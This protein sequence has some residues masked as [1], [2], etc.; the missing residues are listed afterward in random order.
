MQEKLMGKIEHRIFLND[1]LTL[2]LE[3]SGLYDTLSPYRWVANSFF[4]I[5][6]KL[7]NGE[8][9]RIVSYG[10]EFVIKDE[11]DFRNWIKT[12]FNTIGNDGFQKYLNKK[13][14]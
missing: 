5:N 7:K 13:I 3:S 10:N 2:E 14:D 8:K 12:D 11:Q 4:E 9:L 6:Q 1:K